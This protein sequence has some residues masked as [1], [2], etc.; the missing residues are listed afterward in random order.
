[1]AWKNSI[2]NTNDVIK[3]FKAYFMKPEYSDIKMFNVL[4]VICLF[5]TE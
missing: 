4:T 5:T 1:M 2:I 3:V